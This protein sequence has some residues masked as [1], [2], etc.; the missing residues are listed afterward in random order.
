M[1]Y[2]YIVQYIWRHIYVKLISNKEVLVFILLKI[3][4]IKIQDDVLS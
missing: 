4:S 3:C 2:S 1:L